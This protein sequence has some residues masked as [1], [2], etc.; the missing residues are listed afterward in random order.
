MTTARARRR[1]NLCG[2]ARR[3][4]D[5]IAHFSRLRQRPELPVRFG[6]SHLGRERRQAPERVPFEVAVKLSGG[7]FPESA[8][9]V[10]L[11]GCWCRAVSWWWAP[12]LARESDGAQN[13]GRGGRT[14]AYGAPR[15]SDLGGGSLPRSA[16][17]AGSRRPS[18]GTRLTRGACR[19]SARSTSS[20]R[21]W[22]HETGDLAAAC[23]E[24]E[25]VERDA[26]TDTLAQAMNR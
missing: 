4:I 2:S 10:I 19:A 12:N 16:A 11:C 17:C 3:G 22:L 21:R 18:P 25:V 5:A 23:L 7:F 6:I 26:V 14:C 8:W 24:G 1:T 13:I 15:T 20:R 9:T